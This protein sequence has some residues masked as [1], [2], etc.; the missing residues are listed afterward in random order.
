[1]QYTDFLSNQSIYPALVPLLTLTIADDIQMYWPIEAVI[2][3]Y[4]V[5]T[6]TAISATVDNLTVTLPN[7]T[8]TAPGQ[9]F[10]IYNTGDRTFTL[11]FFGPTGASVSFPTGTLK[12]FSL[13]DNTTGSAD[14]RAAGYWYQ[15]NNSLGTPGIGSIGMNADATQ[16]NLTI[17]PSVLTS[18]GV[19]D[20]ALGADLQELISFGNGTGFATR[21]AADTWA[22]RTFEG[23]NDQIVIDHP[24]GIGG[25]PTFSL[26][27]VIEGIDAIR[28]GNLY[29]LDGLT[30]P[31]P[32]F[33]STSV[34][35]SLVLAASP[36]GGVY[37]GQQNSTASPALPATQAN[38]VFPFMSVANPSATG[39]F[40]ICA[41]DTGP[42]SNLVTQCTLPITLPTTGQ[43]IQA[44]AVST[45]DSV[46]TVQL[47]YAN[48]PTIGATTTANTLAMFT[49]AAGT[50]V[51]TGLTI[52]GANGQRLSNILSLTTGFL[53]IDSTGT[54]TVA[55]AVNDQIGM[56]T[57]AVAIE[58]IA[59]DTSFPVFIV[60]GQT[61][62]PLLAN[63][64]VDQAQILQL[65]AFAVGLLLGT[66]LIFYTSNNSKNITFE[67]PDSVDE[68]AKYYLP[69]TKP[70]GDN[71]PLVYTTV[72]SD[73]GTNKFQLKWGEVLPP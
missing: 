28:I 67:L 66:E 5:A 37:I 24:D 39:Y 72:G 57:K 14:Q 68:S 58:S 26:A 16:G 8:L 25:P 33:Y 44:T 11:K 10:T 56:L 32:N 2:Q 55:D 47:G 35:H 42:S 15:F 60:G 45:I 13:W 7:A 23:T 1:M 34:E 69:I 61:G 4:I 38:L 51:S 17:N 62:S 27:N 36:G 20:F 3:P 9:T 71:Q 64:S 18:N 12:T 48:T 50:L 65:N 59:G 21:T 22:L 29:I 31:N 54:L 19:F 73:P 41:P 6:I 46:A 43:V 53:T 63:I 30:F 52:D 49:D 40:S 70:S